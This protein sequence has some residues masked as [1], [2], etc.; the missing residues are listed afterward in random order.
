[1][2]Y[3]RSGPTHT[4]IKRHK[5]FSSILFCVYA[6]VMK[7][8][9]PAMI[10]ALIALFV[11]L[12]GVAGAATTMITTKMLKNNSVTRAKIA[13]N[14]VNSAKIE[15]G[16]IQSKDLSGNIRG[17]RGPAGAKGARGASGAKGET[18]A[19]GEAGTN[20]T[21]GSNGSSGTNGANGTP[22]LSGTSLVQVASPTPSWT[23]TF[24][25]SAGDLGSITVGAG[26]WLLIVTAS[27]TGSGAGTSGGSSGS[28]SCSLKEGATPIV[29]QST[30][31]ASQQFAIVLTLAITKAVSPASSTT[32]SGVLLRQMHWSLHV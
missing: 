22:G 16:S 15:D 18:G 3:P 6:R 23:G 21:A 7:L 10:V 30:S 31:A 5:Y 24:S 4:Y 8:P 29:T 13:I 14:A 12:G 20:G 17:A 32:S 27:S 25:A 2:A 11:A 26:N 9:S 1:M 19:R 28:I